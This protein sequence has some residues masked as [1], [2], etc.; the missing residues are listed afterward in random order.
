[1]TVNLLIS[2]CYRIKINFYHEQE[3]K[4]NLLP[5][6]Y[7]AICLAICPAGFGLWNILNNQNKYIKPEPARTKRA[8]SLFFRVKIIRFRNCSLNKKIHFTAT[9][10]NGKRERREDEQRFCGIG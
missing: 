2:G 6:V 3:N 8:G 4:Q 1:M 9:K 5:A 10:E 7:H